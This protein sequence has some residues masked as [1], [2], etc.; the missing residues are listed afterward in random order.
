MQGVARRVAC[1]SHDDSLVIG[2]DEATAAALVW[3]TALG[4]ATSDGGPP[5][6]EIVARCAGHTRPIRC[7]AHAPS[8]AAFVSAA[9]DG[10][11]R[12]W[13]RP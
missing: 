1:F 11:V 3:P 7:V 10:T 6:G 13:A 9:E 12:T 8:G 4:G 5:G 2:A